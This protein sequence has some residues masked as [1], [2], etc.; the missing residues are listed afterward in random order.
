VPRRVLFVVWT[1]PLITVGRRTFIAD[2]LRRAGALSVVD[3]KAEW[4]RVSFEE[5]LRLQP[6]FLVFASAHA[7]ETTA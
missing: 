7:A 6:E 3:A 2:A 1:T 5:I 4:P